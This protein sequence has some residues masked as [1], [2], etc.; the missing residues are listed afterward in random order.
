MSPMRRNAR[1]QRIVLT[2]IVGA[3]CAV[4]ACRSTDETRL[5]VPP[6]VQRTVDRATVTHTDR[7]PG[8]RPGGLGDPR[9]DPWPERAQ[10]PGTV[11]PVGSYDLSFIDDGK[12]M[13]GT[14]VIRGTPGEYSGRITAE[15]R[16]QVQ[17]STVTASGPLVT[18]TADVPNGVL[19]LRFRVTGDS[20][21]GDWSLRNDGGRLSGVRRPTGR[22]R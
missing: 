21:H 2:V 16:P 5:A 20:L 22:T 4:A 7:V 1:Q 18:V 8:G 13:T 11:N 9:R 19:L 17:I 10:T 6:T 3:A 12:P 15:A 14:M